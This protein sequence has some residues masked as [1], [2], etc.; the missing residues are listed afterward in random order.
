MIVMST[1]ISKI[2]YELREGNVVSLSGFGKFEMRQRAER[3][4]INPA[5]QE[6][7]LIP[8][9]NNIKFTLS[10]TAKKYINEED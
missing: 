2:M 4:G 10:K 8:A 3:Q 7:I 5:T 9:T 6:K 1:M